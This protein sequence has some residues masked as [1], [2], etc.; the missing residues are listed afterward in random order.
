MTEQEE[1]D[2]K[3]RCFQA[4]LI[5]K[6]FGDESEGVKAAWLDAE[7]YELT[8]VHAIEVFAHVSRTR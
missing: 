2:L 7:Y 6:D 8:G 4:F 1:R 5:A 3:T